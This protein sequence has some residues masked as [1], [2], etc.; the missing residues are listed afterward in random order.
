MNAISASE[1][2]ERKTWRTN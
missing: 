2:C 1:H